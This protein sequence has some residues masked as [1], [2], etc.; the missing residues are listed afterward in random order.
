MT[1]SMGLFS[2]MLAVAAIL[3]TAV[4]A[5]AAHVAT[6]CTEYG[7]VHISCNSTGD[8]CYRFYDSERRSYLE[9]SGYERSYEPYWRNRRYEGEAYNRWHYDCDHDSDACYVRRD[10]YGDW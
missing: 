4:S 7:C 3:T 2:A 9:R 8:R 6:R 1:K 5:Q 10:R